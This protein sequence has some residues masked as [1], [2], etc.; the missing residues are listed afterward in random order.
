[1]NLNICD[2]ALSYPLLSEVSCDTIAD[3]TSGA[4]SSFGGLILNELLHLGIAFKPVL[5]NTIQNQR[6]D[7][8]G[9][10]PWGPFDNFNRASEACPEGQPLYNPGNVQDHS[11]SLSSLTKT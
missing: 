10:S 6:D 1:M 8:G 4:M 2:E 11:S 5:G 9:F 3:R 7:C